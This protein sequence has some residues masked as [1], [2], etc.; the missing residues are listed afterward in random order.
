MDPLIVENIFSKEDCKNLI[1][2]SEHIGYTPASCYTVNG[3]EHFDFNMRKSLRCILDDVNV[4]KFIEEKIKDY[5]PQVYNEKKF[6]SVNERL[7]F[8]KYDGSGHFAKHVDGNYSDDK[9]QS[10][11]T[12]LIYLNEGYKGGFTRYYLNN[13][14]TTII[15]KTGMICL[16]DQEIEHDVPELTEG[17]KYVIRTELMYEL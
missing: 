6:H 8:L 16:M 3:V 17:I 7:R 13:T 9:R 11:I 15:P 1:Y 12:I 10:F 14:M 4:A 5:I 2:V